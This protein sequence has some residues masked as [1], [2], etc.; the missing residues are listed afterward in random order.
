MREIRDGCEFSST[1]V[2]D[3]Q[4]KKLRILG[5]I[6]W[7]PGVNRSIQLTDAHSLTF[8]AAEW[9]RVRGYLGDDPKQR[10]LEMCGDA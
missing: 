7:T 6:H 4:L 5:H 2:V 10:L 8:T 9:E 3:Y 1:S